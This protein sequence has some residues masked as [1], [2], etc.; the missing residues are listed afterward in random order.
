MRISLTILVFIVSLACR[1]QFIDLRAGASFSKRQLIENGS[2]NFNEYGVVGGFSFGVLYA[3]RFNNIIGLRTGLDFN[4]RGYKYYWDINVINDSQSPSITTHYRP[5]FPDKNYYLD[6]PLQLQIYYEIDRN[7]EFSG[8]LGPYVGYQL[9]GRSMH[10]SI[11]ADTSGLQDN[12]I[13]DWDDLSY[14]YESRW[15]YG[16]QFGGSVIVKNFMFEAVFA[17]GIKSKFST[18]NDLQTPYR[19][20]Y[21]S[22]G[23]RF[24]L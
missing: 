16:F 10:G 9:A 8:F 11:F 7:A 15:D 6:L 3:H 17:L 19:S 14:T 23:Y 13:M 24:E 12:R 18:Y 4:T 2:V 1:A 20:V 21:L 5:A 22:L